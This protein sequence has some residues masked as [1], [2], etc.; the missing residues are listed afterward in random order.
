MN[1]GANINHRSNDGSAALSDAAYEQ[2]VAAAKALLAHGADVNN[3][4]SQGYTAIS[5]T[6]GRG[7]PESEIVE[8]LLRNGADVR[9][10]YAMN[11]VLQYVD[12]DGYG[13]HGIPRE[14]F[15][16]PHDLR[17]RHLYEHSLVPMRL[18]EHGR[19]QLL[20]QGFVFYT[21]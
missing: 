14:I 19:Q 1:A 7:V 6:C 8:L 5:W 9:D 13:G 10:L 11:C 3:R 17:E 15:L 18:S 21:V 20:S 16:Q 12:Y 2:N 4:D